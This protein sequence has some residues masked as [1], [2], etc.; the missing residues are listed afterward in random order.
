MLVSGMGFIFAHFVYK[1]GFGQIWV[2]IQN[3]L[4]DF[5]ISIMV[6]NS[7]IMVFDFVHFEY[8]KDLVLCGKSYRI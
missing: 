1:G 2:K 5:K 3:D 8:K 4:I 7:Q 6:L